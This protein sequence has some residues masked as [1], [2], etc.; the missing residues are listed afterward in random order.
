MG[1]AE[2]LFA[3]LAA[4]LL[5]GEAIRPVQAIG[6]AV[7]LLGLALARPANRGSVDESTLASSATIPV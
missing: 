6:G 7:V 3:V 2:V 1:L 5:L 4:W